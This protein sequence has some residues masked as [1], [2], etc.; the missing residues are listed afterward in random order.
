MKKEKYILNKYK[1]LASSPFKINCALGVIG[2]C[3]MF[4]IFM[5]DFA[6]QT[7]FTFGKVFFISI[8]I[9]IGLLSL[10]FIANIPEEPKKYDH[11]DTDFC[12]KPSLQATRNLQR[13]L[14]MPVEDSQYMTS[15]K[16]RIAKTNNALR[17]SSFV[18]LF[19]HEAYI[20]IRNSEKISYSRELKEMQEVA[21]RIAR[22]L[23]YTAT[24]LQ[25][26]DNSKGLP[27]GHSYNEEYFIAHLK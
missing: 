19:E 27:L 5:L 14:V 25:I 24:K 16:T 10:K 8:C 18:V 7:G 26:I 1:F 23:D 11:E 3:I 9:V 15:S 4:I 13:M 17:L 6:G 12:Y 21:N 20:F 22:Q 2:F